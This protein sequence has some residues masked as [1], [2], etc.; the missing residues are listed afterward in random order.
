MLVSEL[1]CSPV[2][3]LDETSLEAASASAA[4]TAPQVF[5]EQVGDVD[6]GRAK[7][8]VGLKVAAGFGVTNFL[9]DFIFGVSICYMILKMFE[10]YTIG[11]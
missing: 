1:S 9:L 8:E 4:G 2:A 10:L 5:L 3:S 7:R 6:E 11:I